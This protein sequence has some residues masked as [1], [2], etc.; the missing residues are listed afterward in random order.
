MN[1]WEFVRFVSNHKKILIKNK[2]TN[3]VNGWPE[4]S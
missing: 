2:S 4:E 1:L 3:G